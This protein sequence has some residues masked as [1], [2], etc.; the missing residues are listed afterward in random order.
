MPP[1]PGSSF[2]REWERL[3]PIIT[4]AV[5]G[6]FCNFGFAVTLRQFTFLQQ[7]TAEGKDRPYSCSAGVSKSWAIT[8]VLNSS[9]KAHH[10]S[11]FAMLTPSLARFGS[12]VWLLALCCWFSTTA[13]S[14]PPQ[15]P[16]SAATEGQQP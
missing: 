11:I 14:Q 4:G 13:L 12:F 15:T 10:T 8:R 16:A 2:I 1:P 9:C 6:G 3:W 5:S 7:G